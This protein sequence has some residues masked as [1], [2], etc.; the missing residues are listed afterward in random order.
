MSTTTWVLCE[1]LNMI[2]ML[3]D[4]YGAL[5]MHWTNGKKGGLV[6]DAL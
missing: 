5:P 6:F 1:D 3:H 2:E 4:K